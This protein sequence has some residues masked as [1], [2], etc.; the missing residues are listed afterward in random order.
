MFK[1]QLMDTNFI[2][3]A[4]ASIVA[5]LIYIVIRNNKFKGKW[6]QWFKYIAFTIGVLFLMIEFYKKEQYG[7]LVIVL[8]GALAFVKLLRDAKSD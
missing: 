7:F 5:V 4:A 3:I 6:L 8:L 1:T 2:F